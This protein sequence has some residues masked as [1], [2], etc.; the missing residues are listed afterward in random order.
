LK[1]LPDKVKGD[2]EVKLGERAHGMRV[3]NSRVQNEAY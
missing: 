1:K 2:I 3:T